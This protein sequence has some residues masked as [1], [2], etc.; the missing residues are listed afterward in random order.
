[1]ENIEL[2]LDENNELIFRV[3]IQGAEQPASAIR[4]V[5]ETGDVAYMFSGT[6]TADGEISVRVPALKEKI[7]EGT[8]VGRLEVLVEGRYFAPL[9]FNTTFKQSLKVVAEAVTRAK[10]I[11]AEQKLQATAEVITVRSEHSRE[12]VKP[13]IVPSKL[14]EKVVP[15]KIQ[16]TTQIQDLTALKKAIRGFIK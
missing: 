4:F 13:K 10:P 5:C 14:V 3:T 2:K 11:I 9:E 8:Y 12:V 15:K 16:E 6:S 1:M 7:R